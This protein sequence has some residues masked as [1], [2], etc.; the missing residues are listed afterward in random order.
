[1]ATRGRKKSIMEPT[2]HAHDPHDVE[3]IERLQQRIQELEFQQLQ[4]D[5]LA[6]EIETESNIW[7]DGSE[8]GNPFGRR[9]PR[10]H[11]DH[12]DN[13]LLTKETESE[14]IIWDIGDKEEEYPFVNKHPKEESMPVYDTDIEDVIEEEEG[15]VG[16][17]GS[18]EEEDGNKDKV[19]YANHINQNGLHSDGKLLTMDV[20][21]LE[22]AMRIR[23]QYFLRISTNYFDLVFPLDW[24]TSVSGDLISLR[25]SDLSLNLLDEIVL[26]SVGIKASIEFP[27]KSFAEKVLIGDS[28]DA[29]V[30]QALQIALQDTCA[31]NWRLVGYRSPQR[32]FTFL[33]SATIS[34]ITLPLTLQ[35]IPDDAV[36]FIV[37]V[38]RQFL[39]EKAFT[40]SWIQQAKIKLS[41]YHPLLALKLVM[42][43]SLVCLQVA[44]YQNI[45]TLA[46]ALEDGKSCAGEDTTRIQIALSNMCLLS[47]LFAASREKAEITDIMERIEMAVGWLQS[48]RPKIDDFLKHYA[49]SDKKN[50]D[51]ETGDT[52]QVELML[53]KQ[54]SG[55]NTQEAKDKKKGK[56]NN[57]KG[58]NNKGKIINNNAYKIELL[59]HYN[60]S[61]TFDLFELSPYFG[62]SED[63]ENSRMSFSQAGEDDAG[64]LDR[65]VNLVEYLEF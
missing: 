27:W 57:S 4:Q 49:M 52:S 24:R 44:Q 33:H 56:G 41:Y 38:C 58:N 60:V 22:F 13:P 2:P 23:L 28:K 59:G 32:W 34:T 16:K 5:S 14:P 61:D 35:K 47:N 55:G 50:Q 21:D 10:F 51:E 3:T 46:T 12:H 48:N 7:G 30:A 39:Y 37:R 8:D 63:E 43:L 42:I 1:M 36:S 11:G 53:E 54:T 65:N 62:E 17:G 15:F 40:A 45:H 31:A 25:E 9:N 20:R 26:Q 6:E 19:V 64:T 29:Y 18:T